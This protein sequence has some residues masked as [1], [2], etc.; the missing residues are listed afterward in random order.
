MKRILRAIALLIIPIVLYYTVF[1]IFEPNNYFGLHEQATGT[2]I[3]ATLRAYGENSPPGIVLGDSRMAKLDTGPEYTNLAFGGAGLKEQLDL[4]EWAI[5]SNPGLNRVV[6]QITFYTL[7]ASYNQDRMIVRALNNPLVYLTNLGYNI[8]MLT[9]L[10]DTISPHREVGD[11]GE[12][13]D[14]AD[15]KYVEY[16]SPIDGK[17]YTMRSQMAEHLEQMYPRNEGWSLNETQLN[18]LLEIIQE[19]SDIE[20]VLVMTPA[21]PLVLQHIADPLG[22]TERMQPVLQQ[23]QNSGAV[24]LDY[25]FTDSGLADTDYFDCFHLDTERGLEKWNRMLLDDIAAGGRK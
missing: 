2:D 19:Y 23:L 25:E 10:Y 21:H 22:I 15:Y 3:V 1:L 4:I 24:L 6:A 5:A 13:T 11:E 12:T 8:N 18:R 17:T 20:F 9:N 16:T 14:P 7:N